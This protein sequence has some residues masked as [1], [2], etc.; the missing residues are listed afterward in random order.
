MQPQ[1][2]ALL[3]TAEGTSILTE[4]IFENRYQHVAEL[5][6]MGAKITVEG[7]RPLSPVCRIWRA[8]SSRLP[9][10]EQVPPFSWQH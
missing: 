8:L 6:R 5:M 10:S 3:T 2:L 4:T 7:E 9:T 1:F